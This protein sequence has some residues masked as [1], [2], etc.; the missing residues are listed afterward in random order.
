MVTKPHY[1]FPEMQLHY[2]KEKEKTEEETQALGLIFVES[3][4]FRKE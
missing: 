2:W 4:Y 3:K 1:F